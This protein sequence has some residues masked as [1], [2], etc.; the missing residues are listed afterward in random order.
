MGSFFTRVTFSPFSGTTRTKF[1]VVLPGTGSTRADYGYRYDYWYYR[2][3][4]HFIL[5]K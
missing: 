3:S 2:L 4:G 1:L 5:Y